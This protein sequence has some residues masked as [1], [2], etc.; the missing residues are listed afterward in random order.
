MPRKKIRY[1][2]EAINED[3]MWVYENQDKDAST[4]SNP[5]R[6]RMLLECQTNN[7]KFWK[8]WMPLFQKIRREKANAKRIAESNRGVVDSVNRANE[9]YAKRYQ[10]ECKCP[11]CGQLT[12]GVSRIPARSQG[13][14]LEPEIPRDL[15]GESGR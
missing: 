3:L 10:D 2:D 7:G 6:A 13:A 14:N 12:Q 5:Q 8:D 11:K 4:I 9:Y 1:A 15:I